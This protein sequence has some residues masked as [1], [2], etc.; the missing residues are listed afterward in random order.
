[1]STNDTPPKKAAAKKTTAAIPAPRKSTARKTAAPP[2]K[3]TAP[4]PRNATTT[5]ADPGTANE[6]AAK[7]MD[8][9]AVIKTFLAER[10]RNRQ[11]R[12]LKITCY[13]MATGAMSFIGLT[14]WQLMIS[15]PVAGAY[16][17]LA[18][19]FVAVTGVGSTVYFHIRRKN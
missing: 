18:G 8:K 17:G 14:I 3:A 5:P 16:A 7:A 9:E 15:S 4:R 19:V 1:M 2:R 11:L 13:V 12:A 6:T 10:H